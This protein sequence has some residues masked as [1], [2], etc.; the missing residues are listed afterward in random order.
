MTV[1]ELARALRLQLEEALGPRIREVRIFG[2]RARGTARPDSDLDLF[3]LLD[4]SDRQ[5][6][7]RIGEIAYALEM[8]HDFDPPIST[9]VLGEAEFERLISRERRIA[10]DILK[11]GIVV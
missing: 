6:R 2:S 8:E 1:S 9:L 5:T 10:L 7:R 11:E 4:T 3:I